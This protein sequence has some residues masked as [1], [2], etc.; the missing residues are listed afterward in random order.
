M[1]I[2]TTIKEV[3]ASERP[4]VIEVHF[5]QEGEY[6]ILFYGFRRLAPAAIFRSVVAAGR[7]HVTT[8]LHQFKAGRWREVERFE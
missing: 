4:Y 3:P 7:W 6:R 1:T 5:E 2:V 8:L